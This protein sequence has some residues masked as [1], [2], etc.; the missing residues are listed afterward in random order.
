MKALTFLVVLFVFMALGFSQGWQSVPLKGDIP[1][2][3]YGHTMVQVGDLYYLFGGTV[4][5]RTDPANDLYQYNPT[6]L[7]FTK[8]NPSGDAVPGMSGQNAVTI[9]GKMVV[10][11]GSRTASDNSVYSFDPNVN[12]WAKKGTQPFA[13]RKDSASA[14]GNGKL[15]V[16]AG[17]TTDGASIYS[18]TWVYDI[19]GDKWTKG[20]DMPWGGRYGH[21]LTV[22]DGV[23]YVV[24]GRNANGDQMQS[25]GYRIANGSWDF[26]DPQG[27]PPTPRSLAINLLV[28]SEM[29]VGGG[30]SESTAPLAFAAENTLAAASATEFGDLWK[31]DLSKKPPAWT[32][33]QKDGPVYSQA[34]GFIQIGVGQN[35]EPNTQIMVFG[36]VKGGTPQP[37]NEVWQYNSVKP[38]DPPP[39][40]KNIVSQI[41][42]LG[43]CR[44]AVYFMAFEQNQAKVTVNIKWQEANAKLRLYALY[45]PWVVRDQT[46]M[47]RVEDYPE[48]F[49]AQHLGKLLASKETADGKAQ[50]I[51]KTF[52]NLKRGTLILLIINTGKV[53]KDVKFTMSEMANNPSRVTM[54]FPIG[55]PDL[56]SLSAANTPRL[57]NIQFPVDPVRYDSRYWKGATVV[58]TVEK[59]TG[60]WKLNCLDKT[61]RKSVV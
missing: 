43:T 14:V 46:I 16:S 53:A 12:A 10:L 55:R 38:P 48:E 13:A 61:D 25:F 60:F 41:G 33:V 54:I 17:R 59:G 11:G 26:V 37:M 1:S 42:A 27:V 50:E 57:T 35:G 7:T 15:I 23:A 2:A 29:Y 8:L 19:A 5:G 22:Y 30:I 21:S 52:T 32:Q 9:D 58:E 31:L 56:F 20:A 36:G 47:G 49:D 40:N 39:T 4:S 3:R 18:D 34:A 28:G 45:T 24:G 44:Y 6:T 51:N